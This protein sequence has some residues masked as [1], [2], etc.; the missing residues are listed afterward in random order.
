MILVADNKEKILKEIEN[1]RILIFNIISEVNPS[2]MAFACLVAEID[3]EETEDLSEE[4]I[5]R[6]LKRL[7]EIGLTEREFK[8]K[9]SEIR[10]K[11]YGDLEIYYPDIFH[12]VLSTAFWAKMKEKALKMCDSILTGIPIEDEMNAADRYFASLIKPKSFS[13]KE[14]EELR[15]DKNFE[16]N[17][18]MLSSMTNKPVKELTTK[19]YFALIQHYNDSL[20][21]RKSN[22]KGR[23]N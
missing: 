2:H 13:G 6:T 4:G 12:N 7:N 21:G 3:G 14:N 16:K 10:E 20:N 5:R 17:C 9:M 1:L 15:Y 19:E 18:I 23:Y 8:K 22:P 11:V